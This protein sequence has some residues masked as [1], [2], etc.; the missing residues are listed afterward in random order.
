MLTNGVMPIPPARNIAGLAEFLCS[1]KETIGESIATSVPRGIFFSERLNAVS[2]MR[3]ANVEQ[4]F[5][6][7]T[8][9]R[10]SASVPLRVSFRRILPGEP[11]GNSAGRDVRCVQVQE[12]LTTQI[13]DAIGSAIKPQGVGVVVEARHLCM[14]MR[15]VEKQH[16]STITS[17]MLGAFR[18]KET[19]DEFLALI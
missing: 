11:G 7:R 1:V 16:S 5:K 12:R 15:G 14:M 3:V 13:A 8:G 18:G 19:R 2:R 6:W 17:S 9:D 4:V 10:K